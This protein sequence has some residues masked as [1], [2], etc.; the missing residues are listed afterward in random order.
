MNSE[1]QRISNSQHLIRDLYEFAKKA[2]DF[3]QDATIV[4]KKD[5]KNSE[6]PIGNT[7]YYD[8]KN[9]SVTI[10]VTGR[11]PKDILRSF[12]HELVHH[13]QNCQG[14]FS[15]IKGEM[16]VGYASKNP[17]L[18]KMEEEAYLEGCMAVRDYEDEIKISLTSEE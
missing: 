12:A 4:I 10:Y 18:R 13:R 5:V 15:K 11:H 16:G 17:E 7:A 3:D 8:P 2:L 14:R 1:T 9:M 6:N